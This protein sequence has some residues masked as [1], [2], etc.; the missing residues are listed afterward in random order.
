MVIRRLLASH[1]ALQHEG[2]D[3]ARRDPHT[4]ALERPVPVEGVAQGR[5]RQALTADLVSFIVSSRVST[6]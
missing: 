3:A 6:M 1:P 4:E 5:G 2:L